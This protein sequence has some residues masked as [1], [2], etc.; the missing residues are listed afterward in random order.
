MILPWGWPRGRMPC[1]QGYRRFERG[2]I[3][4]K[5]FFRPG[6]TVWLEM[7]GER[8][9]IKELL[10]SGGQGQV[11]RALLNG[12]DCALKWYFPHMATSEQRAAI[13]Q[14]VQKGPPNDCFLW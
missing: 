14:L 11:Y 9:E 1:A 4:M 7:A 10:G 12:R 13:E 3:F 5:T 6:Q 2:G 8:S